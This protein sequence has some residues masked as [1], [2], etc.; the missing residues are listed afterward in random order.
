MIKELRQ[1]FRDRRTAFMLLVAPVIQL[2]VLGYSVDLDVDHIPTATVDQDRS[3]RSRALLNA[4]TAGSTFE[5]VAEPRDA[6]TAQG[7]IEDGTA[8]VAVVIPPGFERDLSAGRTVQI[9][10]LIDG[11]DPTR[12]QV[13]TNAANQFINARAVEIAMEQM[14]TRAA[15]LGRAVSLPQI[16]LE[17]RVYYNPTLA[18]AMYMVPGVLAMLLVLVSTLVTAMGLARE[19]EAGT[20]EQL[21]VTP[22]QPVVLLAGKCLP[23]AIL[24]LI[25]V[26]AV[27]LAGSLLFDVPMRGPLLVIFVSSA[28]YLMTTLGAGIFV[29]TVTRSQQQAVLGVFFFLMPA[30]LLSGF[31]T[32][33]ENMPTWVQPITWINPMRYYVEIL[34]ACLLKGAGFADLYEP[35]LALSGFGVVILTVSSLG[36]RKQMA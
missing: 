36:F 19:R 35:F 2:V 8:T 9:Q 21:M 14:A 13:A 10:F 26:A 34:R 5:R 28:L 27:L 15:G 12:A 1:A 33:I 4:L 22:I 3:P 16:R 11:S 31:M 6:H 17:P 29:S 18:S 24:G 25:D 30:V 23:F 32:P 7:L 20:M